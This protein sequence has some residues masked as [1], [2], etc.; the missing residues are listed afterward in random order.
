V[1]LEGS[2]FLSVLGL[3]GHGAMVLSRTQTVEAWG[4]QSATRNGVQVWPNDWNTGAFAHFLAR[5]ALTTTSTQDAQAANRAKAQVGKPYNKDLFSIDQ[6][7]SYY[8]SQLVY[9]QFKVL[10]NA[11]LNVGGGAVPPVDLANTQNAVTIYSK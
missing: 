9:R 10:F 4:N 5:T 7:N 1:T 8:C 11:D 3:N 2:S 6:D